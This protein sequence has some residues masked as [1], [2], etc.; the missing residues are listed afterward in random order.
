MSTLFICLLALAA[1]S[2][3]GVY[4]ASQLAQLDAPPSDAR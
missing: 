1:V 2:L 4:T 3:S